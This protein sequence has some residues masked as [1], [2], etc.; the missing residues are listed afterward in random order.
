[1]YN[2]RALNATKNFLQ[3]HYGTVK[4]QI[5]VHPAI[6]HRN[7]TIYTCFNFTE[8]KTYLKTL[9]KKSFSQGRKTNSIEANFTSLQKN[10]V[11]FYPFKFDKILKARTFCRRDNDI[12]KQTTTSM[13][14]EKNPNQT[15]FGQFKNQRYK[16][17][18]CMAIQYCFNKEL[19]EKE[20]FQ[21]HWP[22]AIY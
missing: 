21:T 2:E 7:L 22:K 6:C 20:N 3:H 12:V 17:T 19:H 16:K 9:L 5:T 8:N 1:M 18:Y 15:E 14:G 13:H 4:F 11:E 10:P